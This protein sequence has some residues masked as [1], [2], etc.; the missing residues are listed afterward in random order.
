MIGNA[1]GGLVIDTKSPPPYMAPTTTAMIWA[2][3]VLLFIILIKVGFCI[4]I[5][6]LFVLWIICIMQITYI[7]LLLVF[8]KNM[9]YMIEFLALLLIMQLQISLQLIYLRLTCSLSMVALFFMGA[10][11]YVILLT[12]VYKMV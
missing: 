12:Y 9:E 1:Y 10:V 2:I 8:L 3:F 5:P 6:L 7:N 11:V 4:K